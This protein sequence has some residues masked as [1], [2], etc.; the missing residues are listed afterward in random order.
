MKVTE[1]SMELR[2]AANGRLEPRSV[3][4]HIC[5]QTAINYGPQRVSENSLEALWKSKPAHLWVLRM[6]HPPLEVCGTIAVV[7]VE[8]NGSICLFYG[9]CTTAV[10]S[11]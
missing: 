8:R 7:V 4:D 6:L 11:I 2:P 1:W 3:S 9:L 10:G 5:V